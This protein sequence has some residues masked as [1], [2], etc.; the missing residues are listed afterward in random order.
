MAVVGLRTEQVAIGDL[1]RGCRRRRRHLLGIVDLIE[2]SEQPF[3]FVHL[4]RFVLAERQV[5]FELKATS[6]RRRTGRG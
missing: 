5:S 4:L 2:T 6:M 3:E 1:R